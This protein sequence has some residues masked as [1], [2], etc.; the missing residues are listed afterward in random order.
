M[1]RFALILSLAAAWFQASAEAWREYPRPQMVRENWTSLSGHWDYAIRPVAEGIPER[2]DGKI[3]VPFPQGSRLSGVVGNLGHTNAL[4]YARTLELHPRAGER[5]LLH[6]DGC[7]CRTMVFLNGVEAMDVPHEA[8]QLAFTVDL[9]KFAKDGAN[10]LDVQVWDPMTN[11][12]KDGQML[13]YFSSGKQI[14]N[15]SHCHYTASSGFWAPV[16]IE[17]VPEAYIRGYRVTPDVD[18]GTVRIEVKVEGEG[19]QR[20]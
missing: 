4:W 12:R 20:M 10:R 16:W 2:F 18:A 1:S 11:R 5:I 3:L 14:L 6:V 17:T 7:D 9:T 13:P 8:T 19:E 15:P